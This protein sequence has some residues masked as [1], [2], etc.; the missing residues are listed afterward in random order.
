MDSIAE[1]GVAAHWRYKEGKK[2]NAKEEQKEIEDKLSWFKNFA[3]YSAEES[4]TSA[5]EYMA[6][7][8]HDVFEA[9]VYVMTPKGRVIDLPNGATPVDLAYRVHT[10]IGHTCVG[11]VVNDTMVPLNTELQTGDVV[12]IKTRKGSGPSEDWLKFVKTNQAKNKIRAYLTKKETEKRSEKIEEGE[13]L[14]EDELRRRGFDP[15]EYTE[16]KKLE[17]IYREFRVSNYTDFMYGIS[18]KS[19]NPTIVCEK[20]TNQKGRVSEDEALQHVLNR[21]VERKAS[22]SGLLIPGIASM[23]MSIAHCCQPVYGDDIVGFITKG[24]GVKVHRRDCVNVNAEGAR[25]IDV[26]WA[27]EDPERTYDSDLVVESKDRNFL[28]TDIVTV[29]SQCKMTLET[30]NASINHDTLITTI[31]MTVR[32]RNKDALENLMANL[33]K[34]DAVLY[35]ERDNH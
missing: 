31:K 26:Q 19:I 8:Q 25:L 9:N 21:E 23:K 10:D 16:K 30:V 20:L 18:V 29:V 5:S 15:K 32:V 6:T 7:L 17:N 11:A 14:L 35:V 24:E 12:E 3:T 2:Y 27:A 13:K 4:N 34:V 28:L 22:K 1:N 33:R